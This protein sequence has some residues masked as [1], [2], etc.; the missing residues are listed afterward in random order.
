MTSLIVLTYFIGFNLYDIS[1]HILGLQDILITP[2]KL[3]RVSNPD[4]PYGNGRIT[5]VK[6][7]GTDAL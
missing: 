2:S 1:S 7:G 6:S 3:D 4:L 5:L